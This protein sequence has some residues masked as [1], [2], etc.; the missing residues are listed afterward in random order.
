MIYALNVMWNNLG[1]ENPQIC[2][3]AIVYMIAD[4]PSINPKKYS[5][6]VSWQHTQNKNTYSLNFH[7]LVI[8]GGLFNWKFINLK[9]A[10]LI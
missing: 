1:H 9:S 2:L 7:F 4:C 10:L 5:S 6:T 8:P 3:K